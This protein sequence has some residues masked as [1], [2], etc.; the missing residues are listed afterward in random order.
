MIM[1]RASKTPMHVLK[2][3]QEAKEKQY[4]ELFLGN[5]KDSDTTEKLTHIPDEIFE[6]E[7]FS[8]F[9]IIRRLPKSMIGKFTTRFQMGFITL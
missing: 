1:S 2:K 9:V 4:K 3:I 6:L 5:T 8:T 7:Q